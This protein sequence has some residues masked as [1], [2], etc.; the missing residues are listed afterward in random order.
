MHMRIAASPRRFL[1]RDAWEQSWG[2]HEDPSSVLWLF[3]QGTVAFQSLAHLNL[4]LN[5]KPSSLYRKLKID[6]EARKLHPRTCQKETLPRLGA[7]SIYIADGPRATSK[8]AWGGLGEC[9][10]AHL[11]GQAGLAERPAHLSSTRSAVF[12]SLLGAMGTG[13]LHLIHHIGKD[14]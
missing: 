8:A 1:G 11:G 2:S 12:W 5:A 13:Q 4:T 10:L 14:T 9:S 7:V 3:L 6:Q